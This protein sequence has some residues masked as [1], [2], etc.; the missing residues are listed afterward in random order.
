MRRDMFVMFTPKQGY[1]FPQH[2][3]PAK[4]VG[5]IAPACDLL[6]RNLSFL[7]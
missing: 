7:L 5:K 6:Y 2:I 3:F 1:G 4:N